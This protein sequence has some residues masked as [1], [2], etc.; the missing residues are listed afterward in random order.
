MCL[1]DFSLG[2]VGGVITGIREAITGEKIKDPVEMAKVELQLQNLENALKTG[3]LEV[4]KAE[5][6]HSSIFV[7]GWRPFVGWV[8]GLSLA[9]I[10]ILEPVMRFVATLAGYDG[11]FPAIDTSI[12]LQ[13]L[14]GMLGIGGMRSFDKLKKTDTKEMK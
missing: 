3:Q 13:V 6:Q 9:Y 1:V 2:D 14:L 11:S 12:T 5:A 4:N 10:A 7:A 8:G